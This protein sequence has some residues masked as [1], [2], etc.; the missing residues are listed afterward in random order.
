M[1]GSDFGT[2]V[3][4]R[5]GGYEGRP[6]VL[7]VEN[8]ATTGMQEQW[9]RYLACCMFRIPLLAGGS[10]DRCKPLHRSQPVKLA[11]TSHTSYTPTAA[12]YCAMSN[13]GFSNRL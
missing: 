8:A 2:S 7:D 10:I 12:M 6:T 11:V 13:D 1:N 3:C 5:A 4:R 9:L